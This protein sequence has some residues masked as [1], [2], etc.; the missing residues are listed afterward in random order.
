VVAPGWVDTPGERL[1]HTARP[2][3]LHPLDDPETTRWIPLQRRIEAR[4]I[5]DAVAYLCS[6]KSSAITGQ[7]LY[8]D[9][10]ITTQTTQGA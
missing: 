1:V 7:I 4:E 2:G 5:A 3:K 9:C 10:G 6:K 8:V